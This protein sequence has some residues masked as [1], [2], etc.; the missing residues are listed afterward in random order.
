M[1]DETR[2]RT[3]GD[4]AREQLWRR[5]TPYFIDVADEVRN[6]LERLADDARR[7]FALVC[8][9]RAMSW[10]VRLPETEQ[11]PFTLGW[12]PVLEAIRAGLLDDAE[13]A[14][15]R[16]RAA[17]DAYRATQPMSAKPPSGRNA[18][19]ANEPSSAARRRRAPLR[20]AGGDAAANDSRRDRAIEQFW[21]SGSGLRAVG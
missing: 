7:A 14:G 3:R 10:H 9:E 11:R 13:K 15:E 16:V 12:R 21:R 17:L 4:L 20:P 5:G 2:Y 8:A 19:P 1:S 18:W 6:R